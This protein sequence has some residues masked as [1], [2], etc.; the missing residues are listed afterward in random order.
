MCFITAACKHQHQQHDTNVNTDNFFDVRKDIEAAVAT[1]VGCLW[2]RLR[3]FC[4][5]TAWHAKLV[6]ESLGHATR[7]LCACSPAALN[8]FAVGIHYP[9]RRL[10]MHL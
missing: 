5:F 7:G 2:N 1:S 6:R 3:R 4:Q 10:R 9:L 8:L